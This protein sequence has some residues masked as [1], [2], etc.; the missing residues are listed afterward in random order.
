[1][2]V[3]F[4]SAGRLLGLITGF[5]LIGPIVVADGIAPVT[6]K[7]REQEADRFLVQWRVPKQLP[8]H[9][10]PTP[11]FPESCRSVGERSLTERPSAWF[12]R[13]TYLCTDGLSGQSIGIDYPFLNATVS[14]LL[15][16]ELLSGDRYAHLLAPGEPSWRVPDADA[17][18]A[19]RWFREAR[20]AVLGGADHFFANGVHVAFAVALVLLGGLAISVRLA[21]AFAVGQ[22]VAVV[23][24]SIS[25]L[26]LGAPLAEIGVAAAVALLAREALRPSAER[27]QLAVL[28]AGAGLV[29]GL[30]LAQLVSPPADHAGSTIVYYG[31][32]V[33]GM[34]AILLLTSMV[35]SGL[36][37]LVP[38]L[39]SRRRLATVVAYGAGVGAI[40]LALGFPATDSRAAARETPTG[41]QLPN[42]PIPE[43]AAG[44]PASRRVATPFPDAALQSFVTVAPFEVRH[45]VLVRLQ[46]IAEWIDLDAS[47]DVAVDAQDEV[48]RRVHDLVAL[49]TGLTI[50]QRAVEPADARVDFLSLEARGA[51]PRPA[52]VPESVEAAWLGVTTVYLTDSTPGEVLLTWSGFDAEAK[53]PATVTDPESSR[54]IELTRRQPALLWENE[55]SE[56]PTPIVTAIAVEPPVLWTPLLSLVLLG[57]AAAFGVAALRGRRREPSI[58]LA[59]VALACAFLFAPVGNV[60]MPLPLS[61]GRAPDRDCSKRIL[62]RL[63]P[64][65]YRAFEFPTESATYDRLALSITGDTLTEIYL[66][67]RRAVRMEE[68]GGARAS[69][70]AVEVL[71][72][73]SVEPGSPDGFVAD[74]AWTVGG[75]V[76]HFGHR[77]FR[78][79]RYD[80]RVTVVP[81]EGHWKIRSIEVLDEQRLR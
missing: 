67:H 39:Q 32:V 27:R 28:A 73:A 81:V 29:H 65:V 72:V 17:G 49:R 40:A 26:Q 18:G 74:A 68:R 66:E 25:G 47:G 6:V 2:N 37:G 44:T 60:A 45:E 30:G 36:R 4:R 80:A 35:G 48:K 21:T 63:L 62:A 13:Q 5:A 12:V 1:V 11:V 15:Q 75:T 77:H 56:D 61:A 79:N 10:I 70:E 69:V 7:V 23:V 52:P 58:A 9:A 57:S 20:Q 3:P 71:E 46:G 8:P 54:S 33:V 16:I 50:D 78:Q 76:T 22:L 64:N 24:F 34:D 31:L 38:Q 59:R 55:L 19:R 53:V 51:L 43:G 42:L 14:T 41:I